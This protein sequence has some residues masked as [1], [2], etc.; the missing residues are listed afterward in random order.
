MALGVGGWP[1][2]FQA[3]ELL[4]VT[5]LTCLC[6]SFGFL[7]FFRLTKFFPRCGVHFVFMWCLT[8]C[9]CLQPF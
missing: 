9:S 4:F 5:T 1:F 2:Q 8:L 3:L 7:V 6:L